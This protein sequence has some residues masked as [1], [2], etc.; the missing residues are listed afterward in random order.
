VSPKLYNIAIGAGCFLL[1]QTLVWFANNSQFAWDWW[2]D[3]PIIT[4]LIYSFPA[5]LFFWYGSKYSYAAL[6]EAWGSRLLAFGTSYLIFP[7]LTYV[8]LH[9]SMFTPKT[10][11]CV[12]LSIAIVLVQVCFK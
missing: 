1:A 6:G 7:I 5:S 8:I 3:K 2:K 10:M 12:I 11:I 4:C 9:E